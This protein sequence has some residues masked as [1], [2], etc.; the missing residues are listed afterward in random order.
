VLHDSGDVQAPAAQR[1]VEV[2]VCGPSKAA[3]LALLRAGETFSKGE[4][5]WGAARVAR[6]ALDKAAPPPLRT[7]RTRRVPQPVLIGH[8]ASLTPY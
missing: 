8:A 6:P 2:A 7:N 5:G 3:V 1:W 4:D